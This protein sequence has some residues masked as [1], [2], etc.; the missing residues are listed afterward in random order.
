MTTLD[1]VV[2]RIRRE[3]PRAGEIPGFDP[4]NGNEKA[5][6]L[7]LFEAPGPKAKA[8][9]IIS[10]DNPDQTARNFKKQLQEAGIARSEI[11]LWNTV[12]WYIGKQP[13][14]EAG[15]NEHPTGPIRSPNSAD[16]A[17]GIQYLESII[18]AMPKLRFIVLMGGAARHA[19]V[20]LSSV[21]T[22]RIVS[23]HHTSPKVYANNQ[24][25]ETD[26]IR[27]L[28]Y[29]SGAGREAVSDFRP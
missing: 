20:F 13:L 12:P 1:A 17:A 16:I 27:V 2:Q 23:C 19:H 26:N 6:Y 25:A 15:R 3:Q 5:I 10:F 11:A 28:R 18:A 14:G 7:F 29:I 22:A 4:L 8:S 21:T 24:N 9:G